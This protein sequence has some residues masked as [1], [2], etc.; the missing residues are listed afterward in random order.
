MNTP[1]A[2]RSDHATKSGH[3]DTCCVTLTSFDDDHRTN[4]ERKGL[5][6]SVTDKDLDLAQ[7]QFRLSRGADTDARDEAGRSTLLIATHDNEVEDAG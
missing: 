7:S 1:P 3:P 5:L 6:K 4:N 2:R